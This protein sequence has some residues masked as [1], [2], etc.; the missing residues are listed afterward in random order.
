[1]FNTTIIITKTVILS[2]ISQYF[3]CLIIVDNCDILD[4]LKK[5]IVK[6]IK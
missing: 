1:M 5:D 6:L 4:Q 3:I 2:A